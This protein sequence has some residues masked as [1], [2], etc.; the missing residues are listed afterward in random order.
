MNNPKMSFR[1]ALTRH[2]NGPHQQRR[3]LEAEADEI[4]EA[5]VR[6]K[7]ELAGAEQRSRVAVEAAEADEARA[8]AAKADW[9]R[10]WRSS[11]RGSG[12]K[13]LYR[14]CHTM[15]RSYGPGHGA[16]LLSRLGTRDPGVPEP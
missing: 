16:R 2:R 14:A 5:A 10:S 13:E 11:S 3:R 1:E 15:W 8:K 12:G 9:C 7:D 6:A 4:L